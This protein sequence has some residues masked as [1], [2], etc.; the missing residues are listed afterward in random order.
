MV[1][2]IL[3]IISNKN[4]SFYPIP[5]PSPAGEGG[6]PTGRQMAL[7]GGIRDCLINI[8]IEKMP[9]KHK[10]TKIHKALVCCD[11]CLSEIFVP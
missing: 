9:Q 5:G 8:K 6:P 3:S 4:P 2:G 10:N 1:C 11:L 7:W